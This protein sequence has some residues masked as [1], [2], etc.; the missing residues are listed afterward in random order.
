MERSKVTTATRY[1]PMATGGKLRGYARPPRTGEPPSSARRRGRF[2]A[3]GAIPGFAYNPRSMVEPQAEASRLDAKDGLA[4]DSQAA[5]ASW[6]APGLFA[7]LAIAL[8]VVAWVLPSKT[9]IAA[10][11]ELW[12]G[13]GWMVLRDSLVAAGIL[14]VSVAIACLGYRPIVAVERRLWTCNRRWLLL[15]LACVAVGF[16]V[17]ISYFGLGAAPHIPD[18]VSMLFQAK[19]FARGQLYSQAPPKDLQKFFA[20]EYILMDGPRWYGKYFF[21]PSVLLVP[22]VWIGMPWLINPLLS[23]FAVL[24]FYALGK[25]MFGEKVGRVA[26]VLAAI[27]PYRIA[28]YGVMMSHGACLILAMLFALYLIR[29]A[30]DPQRYRYWLI[31]GLTLGMMVNFRPLTALVLAIPLGLGAAGMLRWR[32][33][34]VEAV[35][36]F[37]L[38]LAACLGLFFAYNWALT[39]DAMLTPF[40]HW[41]KADRLGF[42]ANVGMEYWPSYDRGHDIENAFKNLYMNIDAVG[43]NLTGWGRATLLLMAAAFLVRANRGRLLLCLAAFL[44]PVVAYFFYHFSGALASQARYWSE[45]MAFM[46]LLAIGGLTLLRVALAGGYR[47]FGWRACDARARSAVWLTVLGLTVWSACVAFPR[48]ADE[49]GPSYIGAGSAPALKKALRD[50]PLTYALVFTPT[51]TSALENFTL[52]ASMNS[53]NLDG[54]VIYARDLGDKQNRE[55][56]AHY[57]DRKAYRFIDD[58][59]S[60]PHFEPIAGQ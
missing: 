5:P 17:W 22:G 4:A 48:L 35:L 33:F 20:Y 34:R 24:L 21:G 29:A 18:E 57:P 56:Q 27:S 52:G 49:F 53:P 59:F 9:P 28:T 26:A 38:P 15:I 37:S 2:F 43:F 3:T 42:G 19:N 44:G 14:S 30:R 40:E 6:T 51:T 60:S 50:Q 16:S 31:A 32:Q 8:W 45:A 46:M 55:L 58:T 10:G 11:L 39:G 41:S 54:D 25:E 36:A 12:F 13:F 23:A 47:R 7:A 1:H